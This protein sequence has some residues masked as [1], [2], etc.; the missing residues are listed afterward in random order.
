MERDFPTRLWGAGVSDFSGGWDETAGNICIL[1]TISFESHK[2]EL[3]LKCKLHILM[4]KT[5]C[6]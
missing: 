5:C 4:K 1:K 3:I 6:Y 2:G